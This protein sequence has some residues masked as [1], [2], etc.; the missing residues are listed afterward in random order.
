MKLKPRLLTVQA[1]AVVSILLRF[2]FP[3]DPAILEQNLFIPAVPA[4]VHLFAKYSKNL[5]VTSLL[6]WNFIPK[7][8]LSTLLLANGVVTFLL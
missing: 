4:A 1:I 8:D 3:L 2:N 5:I 7:F 6:C